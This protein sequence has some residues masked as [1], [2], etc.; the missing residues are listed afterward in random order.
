M[1]DI[2][3]GLDCDPDEDIV[4]VN[5]LK[6]YGGKKIEDTALIFIKEDYKFLPVKGKVVV[7]IG[8][9]IGDSSIYFVS[10]GAKKVLGL[11]PDT[12]RFEF[13][14]KNIKAN[15][16]SDKI[17]IIHSGGM[18]MNSENS[19]VKQYQFKGL[20][21]TIN[22]PA[23]FMTLEQ[24]IN[25]LEQAPDILKLSCIGCEYDLLLNTPEE[26][27]RKFSHIQV[28]YVLGYR[29]IRD[30]LEK[31][32]FEVTWSG[33]E[34]LKGDFGYPDPKSNKKLVVYLYYGYLYAT[35]K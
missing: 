7:D 29:N 22:K 15:N 31:C 24:I 13:A 19:G 3:M 18:G 10:H 35:R 23:E 27:I 8:A 12:T 17:E 25:K 20:V 26:I 4:Y 28:Q 16:F 11:E 9:G 2:T 14:K 34:L 32:G 1:W 5:G 30:K 33:P 21:D 6:F